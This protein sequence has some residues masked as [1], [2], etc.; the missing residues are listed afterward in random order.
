[1]NSGQNLPSD[2][3]LYRKIDCLDLL[4]RSSL[5]ALP[6]YSRV[7]S[8]RVSG[9][10]LRPAPHLIS[11]LMPF[12]SKAAIFWST[13]SPQSDNTPKSLI[14]LKSRCQTWSGGSMSTLQPVKFV[15]ISSSSI[16]RLPRFVGGSSRG[17]SLD[18]LSVGNAIGDRWN[19]SD[20]VLIVV[21]R[22]V[23][24]PNSCCRLSS[25]QF[26]L[27]DTSVIV[28]QARMDLQASCAAV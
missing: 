27:P 11:F 13:A 2:L 3:L 17:E 26:H 5:R 20:S 24:L 1:M 8:G 28:F 19:K 25:C 9:T 16:A 7:V 4:A 18:L 21:F 15:F 12:F 22:K 6:A 10:L 23:V 14:C